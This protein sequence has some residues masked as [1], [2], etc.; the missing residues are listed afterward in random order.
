MFTYKKSRRQK[1]IIDMYDG[2][3]EQVCSECFADIGA[4]NMGVTVYCT[5][6]HLYFHWHCC[7]CRTMCRGC[8]EA[9]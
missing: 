3:Y 2:R 9:D 1:P 4:P 5:H 8:L 7:G 6:C